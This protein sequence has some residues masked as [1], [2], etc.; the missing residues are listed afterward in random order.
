MIMTISQ[1]LALI[2]L[3]VWLVTIIIHENK[4]YK[5]RKKNNELYMKTLLKELEL[6]EKEK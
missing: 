3:T 2:L 6:G 5:M 4:L 1:V